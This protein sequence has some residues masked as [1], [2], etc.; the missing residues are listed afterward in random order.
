MYCLFAHVDDDMALVGLISEKDVLCIALNNLTGS[1]GTPVM[2]QSV[3]D[4]MTKDVVSFGPDDNI[5]D[6]CQCFIDNVFR[7]VPVLDNGKL[8]GV[9]SKKDIISHSLFSGKKVSLKW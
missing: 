1:S 3:G 7:R 5:T 8:V 9:I 2:S 4:I 6:I